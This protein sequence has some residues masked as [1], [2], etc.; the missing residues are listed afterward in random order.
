[1]KSNRSEDSDDPD[2][3]DMYIFKTYGPSANFALV[4]ITLLYSA[5]LICRIR[6]GQRL[7]T[8]NTLRTYKCAFVFCVSDLIYCVTDNIAHENK[9]VKGDE[10]VF[11]TL[12]VAA[13]QISGIFFIIFIGYTILDLK[14]LYAFMQFQLKYKIEELFIYKSQFNSNESRYTNFTRTALFS[15][16]AF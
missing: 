14:L 5:F 10:Y 7:I 15:I 8:K 4:L 9:E 3:I 13:E 12:T 2:I 11:D 1:M 6:Y 16:G